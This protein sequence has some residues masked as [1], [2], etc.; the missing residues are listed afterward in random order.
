M[1]SSFQL[2]LGQMLWV[3]GSGPFIYICIWHGEVL[4]V[5]IFTFAIRRKLIFL[6]YICIA[7]VVLSLW[8]TEIYV[9][10]RFI[11]IFFN[12]ILLPPSK[13]TQVPKANS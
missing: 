5:N 1:G 4:M 9:Y 2:S 3:K 12:Y 8:L 7:I 10:T 13:F 11:Y 6:F